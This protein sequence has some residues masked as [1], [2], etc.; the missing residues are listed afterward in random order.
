MK[1][2]R[3]T[4]SWDDGHNLDLKMAELLDRYGVKGTFYVAP[5][6]AGVSE[7]AR[8]LPS[9][10][11]QLDERYEV[12]AHSMTHPRLTRLTPR[13]A[14][15]EIRRS[16]AW[17]EDVLQHPVVSFCYPY[18]DFNQ[19]TARTVERAGFRYARTTKRFSTSM[20]SRFAARTTVH[21]YRHWSD[22]LRILRAARFSPSRFWR[23]YSDWSELAIHLF[24]EI[25]SRGGEFHLWGHSW[26]IE[27]HGDWQRLERVLSHVAE[28]TDVEHVTNGGLAEKTRILTVTPYFYPAV[29]GLERYAAKMAQGA[30]DSGCDV[31]VV[32]SS[33]TG[34]EG[35]ELV[36]G[37]RVFRLRTTFTFSNTPIG[38]T[39]PLKLR[40]LIRS[41]SPDLINCHAP[42]PYISD[43]SI[44][45]AGNVPVILTYHSASMKQRSWRLDR[46]I[47][48]YERLILPLSL[49]RADRIICSSDFVRSRFLRKYAHKTSTITPGVDLDVFKTRTHVGDERKVLFVGSFRND[50]KGLTYLRQ[51]MLAVDN[52]ELHVVGSGN[53]VPWPK[54]TYHGVLVGAELVRMIQSSSV[55]VFP[56]VAESESFGM[57]LIEA[58]AC[59]V[60]VIASRMGGIPSVI[61]DGASG[62]LV[63]PRDPKGL[64]EAI[65]RVLDDP[66]LAEALSTYG[67]RSVVERFR[68]TEKI[69][70][71]LNLVRELTTERSR[72]RALVVCGEYPPLVEGGLGVHYK[73]LLDEL[74]DLATVTLLTARTTSESPRFERS[75][76][77]LIHRIRIPS[78]FPLN[79][80][81]FNLGARYYSRGAKWDLQHLCAPFGWLNVV[82]SRTPTV[83]KMHTLYEGQSG[84]F[85]QRK[86]I[87]PLASR[88]DFWLM[89][90]ADLVM[91]TSEYMRRALTETAKV[92]PGKVRVIA[93]GINRQFFL[94]SSKSTAR[95]NLDIE[96]DRFVIVNVGRWVQR[97]GTLELLE[98]FMLVRSRMPSAFL[99]LVGGGHTEGHSYADSV[100]EYVASMR[101]G[102]SV[103]LVN[104][105]PM[106]EVKQY[107]SAADL[108]V[109]PASYEPFG[110]VLLEA[111]A[112]GLPVIAVKAGGPEE[113]LGDGGMLIEANDPQSLASRILDVANDQVL[114]LESQRRAVARAGQFSWTATAQETY[115]DYVELLP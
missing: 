7:G 102:S 31:S 43:I 41:E 96:E 113:V 76:T 84:A 3:V 103:R 109:H 115:E 107:Y 111:M 57:V 81:A 19:A 6:Y 2:V 97:K 101:L 71:Y 49:R 33:K 24:D 75:G 70:E 1:R 34:Q 8:L 100:R 72:V 78:T 56:S 40:R 28:A 82:A 37:L 105:L 53:P 21:A 89:K 88:I 62:L 51:A 92:E 23:F 36:D 18:G 64:A 54:T 11:R 48:T 66:A 74:K 114:M 44:G 9:E 110:N 61:D 4:T 35:Y 14:G 47:G 25:H 10:I 12:G 83:V 29:G 87:F 67:L 22:L 30:V 42:V 104:W 106:E 50:W 112:Q 79:H 26:E 108:Y 60:P 15:E 86:L 95:A 73:E 13:A 91:T 59:G 52:A 55:L 77:M 45:A 90:R 69:S 99:V 16:K 68:W 39:W 38:I 46:L 27:E 5:E 63:P 85:I 32:T 17:L 58:Q 94:R 93:N 80:L 20:R 65:S 98:A